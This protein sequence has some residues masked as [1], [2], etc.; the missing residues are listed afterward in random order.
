MQINEGETLD[1][2]DLEENEISGLASLIRRRYNDASAARNETFFAGKSIETWLVEAYERYTSN[3]CNED[4]NLVRIKTDIVHAKVKD[5]TIG[6]IDAPFVLKPTHIPSLS[7]EQTESI[8]LDLE[9]Q[10]GQKL[11]ENN[12]VIIDESGSIKPRFDAVMEGQRLQPE[13][14]E[15]LREQAKLQKKSQQYEAGLIAGEAVR[16]ATR[17]MMD[18]M[19]EGRWKK[20]NLDADFDDFLYGT[21]CIK[22][23]LKSVKT[24]KWDGPKF[25]EAKE[26]RIVWRHV[27]IHNCYPSPDSEDAQTGTYFIE[28]AEM[29]KQTVAACKEIDWFND[30]N[31]DIAIEKASIQRDWLSDNPETNE[32][33]GD[34]E[35][36]SVIIHQGSVSGETLN[37]YYGYTEEDDDYMEAYQFYDVEAFVLANTVIGCRI[38]Q[39]PYG[40]RTYYSSNYKTAGKSFWGIGLAML[41]AKREDKLNK[42]EVDIEENI[43]KTV[44][45][46]I[47]YN[48]NMFD[49]PNDVQEGLK[50]KGKT[51]PYNSDPSLSDGVPRKPYD[52][53]TFQ[54]K[55]AEL[56]SLFAR[57]YRLADDE[58]GIPSL[59]SGNSDLSGG[60]ATFRGMK[61]L[62]ATSNIII[63]S[64]FHNKDET[65]IQPA[66]QDL[67]YYN[68]LNSDDE[69]IKA[70]ANVVASGVA[71]LMQQDIAKAE[72]IEAMPIISQ[73]LQGSS[74]SDEEKSGIVDFLLRETMSYSGLPAG[75]LMEDP[76]V[77]AEKNDFINSI[78]PATPLPTIGDDTNQGGL[79]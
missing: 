40:Q 69:T 43:N 76:A 28:V 2:T 22:Q 71:G 67:W 31:I 21:G 54:S 7:E 57:S 58:C 38:M 25:K 74:L 35:M 37:E 53:V 77:T 63:K 6:S 19:S 49:N 66:M 55:T 45:P 68:M 47:F 24:L 70:D 62:A 4:F 20:A 41:L 44:Y 14:A 1:A 15:W 33:W 75:Q 60:E 32:G 34:D 64:Y 10:L 26:N 72:M 23:E 61:L 56:S 27:P 16:N 46:P 79:T 18:Q 12:I 29:Q 42:Y 48:M 51:I 30:D 50:G 59:L 9:S 3:N 78:K 73:L 17:L 52:Q 8:Q 13:V 65:R 5:M 36:V 11:V 39:S